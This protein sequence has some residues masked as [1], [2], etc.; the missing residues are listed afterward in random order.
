[1]KIWHGIISKFSESSMREIDKIKGNSKKYDD[2]AESLFPTI[3]GH[4]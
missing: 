4:Q 2:M 1:M 3:Y